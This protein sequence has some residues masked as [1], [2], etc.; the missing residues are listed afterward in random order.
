MNLQKVILQKLVHYSKF[1][2]EYII[3]IDIFKK[4]KK[5]HS[6][7]FKILLFNLL[8]EKNISFRTVFISF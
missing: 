4:V 8:Y 3:K 7:S 6:E 1:I 2:F 5:S